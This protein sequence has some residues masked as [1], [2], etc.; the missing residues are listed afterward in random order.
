M[1]NNS[2]ISTDRK[3]NIFRFI[4][5]IFSIIIFQFFYIQVIKHNDYSGDSASN[6]SKLIKTNAPRGFIKDRNG[7]VIVSNRSTFS[8]EIYPL[9]FNSSAFDIDLFYSIIEKANKRTNFLVTKNEFIDSI[10]Y[11]R[12]FRHRKYRPISIINYI[13]FQTKALLSEYK[14][15]FPGL[16]FKSNPAR[17]YSENL[18]LSHVLG[19]LRPV[20]LE[21]IKQ[22]ND[23]D[24]NDSYGVD[25]IEGKFE[26]QLKGFKGMEWRL[27]SAHGLDYGLDKGKENID[28]KSGKDVKLTID[29]DLQLKIEQMLNNYTGSVICMNPDNG[30]I[31][32]MAS[33]PNFSLNEFIGPL[34]YE[35][36][37][38]WTKEKILLNRAT[39]GL[40]Q[41]GSLYKLVSYIMFMDKNKIS[42]NETVFCDGTFELEDFSKPGEPQIHRCWKEDGHGEVNLNDAIKKS[43]NI[44]FYD[45]ILRYQKK[46]NLII[47]DLH[48]YANK[49]GF[50]K[51]TGIEIFEKHGR[52]PD[53]QWMVK[54]I[55][56]RWPKRGSMP[57]LIIGQG[58]NVITPIQAINAINII[59]TSDN[60]YKPKIVMSSPAI[61]IKSGISNSI[62]SSLQN[63]LLSV[64]NESNG[65]AY[66]I[67]KDNVI[68]RGKTGTAQSRSKSS[69][70]DLISWFLGYVE[71]E[72]K[73]MSI[74]VVIENTDSDNK[75]IAKKIT[76]DII[77]F[78]MGRNQNE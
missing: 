6:R 62:L 2:S 38:E 65:T 30:E 72:N 17:Y 35:T 76:S 41:P 33:A 11:V 78:E 20:P 29:Y 3:N 44:F 21:I 74:V 69:S 1:K 49:L 23:Y 27:M 55:G 18:R 47:N 34:K 58:A 13:D 67:K 31:L 56:K 68:I 7:K 16:I 14:I 60:T 22:N 75:G 37:D 59:A 9:H 25:G 36:W 73:I 50:N 57:N 51:K 10:N 63:A 28:S 52:I 4:L 53:S 77:D 39:A 40:Y 12:K 32:A 71:F 42:V 54:N 24:F 8:I 48:E 46:N 15:H 5:I 70:E 26:N 19:Y 66:N 64:V 43:C 61:P 45:L